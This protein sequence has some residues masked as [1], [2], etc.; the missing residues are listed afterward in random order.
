MDD[1]NNEINGRKNAW[2]WFVGMLI[3]IKIYLFF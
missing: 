3:A 2:V 1:Q